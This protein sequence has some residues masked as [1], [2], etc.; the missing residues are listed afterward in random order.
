MF[1][2]KILVSC[3]FPPSLRLGVHVTRDE[4][5]LS[6]TRIVMYYKTI[7]LKN[8]F[9]R[10]M[11]KK[12]AFLFSPR[13][14]FSNLE[15]ISRA[16]PQLKME[17]SLENVLCCY[18]CSPLPPSFSHRCLSPLAALTQ[19][20]GGVAAWWG[21][22]A[23]TSPQPPFVLHVFVYCYLSRDYTLINSNKQSI[24]MQFLTPDRLEQA[25]LRYVPPF[26]R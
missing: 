21:Q 2:K 6:R 9:S 10:I 3:A 23:C 13:T 11:K 14:I 16:A 17:N 26:P 20:R 24:L 1:G 4:N 25:V 15:K 18:C 8:F 22:P 5:L 7:F 12:M 19:Q